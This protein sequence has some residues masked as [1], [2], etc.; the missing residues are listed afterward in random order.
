MHL[1]YA[2]LKYLNK[3]HYFLRHQFQFCSVD[4]V[5]GHTAYI[6]CT[7]TNYL[8][9]SMYNNQQAYLK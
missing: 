8:T 2:K 9:I 4:I 5:R 6:I 7:S 3:K 1:V